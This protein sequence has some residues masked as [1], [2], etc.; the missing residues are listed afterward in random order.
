MNNLFEEKIPTNLLFDLV[1]LFKFKNI[2]IELKG[3]GSLKNQ[4]YPSDIDLF[5]KINEKYSIE[6]IYQEFMKILNR[7]DTNN[8]YF[9]E[10]KIQ[11]SN[12]DKLKFYK[13]ED[14]TKEKFISYFNNVEF[15]KI[16]Y[17]V[18][19]MGIFTELSAIYSFKDPKKSYEQ[20]IKD[21]IK[22]LMKEKQYYK[23]LKRQ[24]SLLKS[25]LKNNKRI[26]QLLNFF[27]SDVGREY[28]R[29][30]NLKALELL[31]EN[32]NDAVTK[33][34]IFDNLKILKLKPSIRQIKTNI[35]RL[36]KYVNEEA[37]KLINNN[38]K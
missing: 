35:N 2:P 15:V 27:N 32:Y 25:D 38:N 28:A 18:R 16:D 34:L 31:I 3:S 19:F 37:H 1:N 4:L 26:I 5:S 17:V 24:L 22:Q 6:D 21:D 12:G 14:I 30:N 7:T 29:M 8:L 13:I 10:F 23:V 9:I 11:K 33:E 20:T 36:Q